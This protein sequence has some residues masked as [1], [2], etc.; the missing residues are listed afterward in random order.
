MHPE[1][2]V[3]HLCVGVGV[4]VCVCTCLYVCVCVCVCFNWSLGRS[5]KL[6][7]EV[8]VLEAS[9]TDL[10]IPRLCR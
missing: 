8:L 2:S 5:I 10:S 6:N 7:Y 9:V 3:G 1:L 4:G